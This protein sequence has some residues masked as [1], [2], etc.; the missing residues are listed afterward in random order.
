MLYG[1]AIGGS[2]IAT[3]SVAE[4]IASHWLD[5]TAVAIAG[6]MGWLIA[7][8]VARP[9]V[10][11]WADRRSAI[12]VLRTHGSVGWPAS[13][14]PMKAAHAAVRAAAAQML[15]Y[16]EA[17][18]SIVRL[19][20]KIL[21]YDLRLAGLALNGIDARIGASSFHNPAAGVDP[22]QCDA[23]RACLGATKTMS[24]SRIAALRKLLE[25]ADAGNRADDSASR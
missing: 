18:P 11:F 23:V 19:Y 3:S 21:R 9:L 17:G 14:E 16:A 6:A 24:K 8:A 22:P 2:E 7:N 5:W 1:S 4:W 10:H 15:F 25:D 12:E 13:D 20:C